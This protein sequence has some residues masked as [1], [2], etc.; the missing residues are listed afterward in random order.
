MRHRYSFLIFLFLLISRPAVAQ[1]EFPFL[2][3]VTGE[4]VNIRAGQSTSFE[5]IGQLKTGEQ[6]VVL[7]KDYGWYKIKLPI[8]VKAYINY[9]FIKELDE[10][11][12]EVTGDRVNIRSGIG[13]D[14]PILGQAAQGQYVRILEKS[15]DW[16]R[17]EPTDETFGWITEGLVK[18]ISKE[19]PGARLVEAPTRNIYAKQRVAEAEKSAEGEKPAPPGASVPEAASAVVVPTPAIPLEPIVIRKEDTPVAARTTV[20]TVFTAGVIEDLA[21]RSIA[22]DIYCMISGDNGTTYYL[23]A[24]P[25]VMD[26]FLHRQVTVEGVPQSDITAPHPV[27]LITKI[28]LVL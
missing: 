3:E 11:T 25:E 8:D 6:V 13:S 27:V 21:E 24:P 7:G 1:E 26:L 17:I 18:F 23:K 19:L 22:K 16:Y 14:F 9:K 20:P 28:N 12:G 4:G 10:K 2:G 5:K 15:E